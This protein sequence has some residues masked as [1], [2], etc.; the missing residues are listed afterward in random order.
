MKK[1]ILIAV[2]IFSALTF[3]FA[4]PTDFSGNWTLDKAKSK[5]LPFFYD[6]V[7]SHKLAITQSE[8]TL[9]VA[10]E[11]KDGQPEL[12]KMEFA[13]NLDGTESKTES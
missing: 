3:T 4:K 5:D 10:V 9:Q 11:I 2:V 7:Q 12:V 13:Y 1:L 8:K 6:N